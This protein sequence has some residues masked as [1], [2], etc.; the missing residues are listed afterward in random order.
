MHNTET[1][2]DSLSCDCHEI[3]R[4]FDLTVCGNDIIRR[5]RESGDVEKLWTNSHYKIH[6][7]L[8]GAGCRNA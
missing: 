3:K 2:T 7:I 4:T 6:L 5:L 1:Y 8:K